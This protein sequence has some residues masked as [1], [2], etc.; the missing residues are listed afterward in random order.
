MSMLIPDN[1]CPEDTIYFNGAKVLQVI[2]EE[3]RLAIADLYV[4]LKKKSDIS[5]A[6]MLLCLDWLY[7]MDCIEVN[8]GE[9]VLCS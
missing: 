1:I 6:T 8:N 9:V 5:F 3:K 4:I 7:L 2:L